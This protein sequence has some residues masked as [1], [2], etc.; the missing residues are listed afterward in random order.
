MLRVHTLLALAALAAGAAAQD[1]PAGRFVDISAEAGIDTVGVCGPRADVKKWILEVNGGGVALFDADGDG[2]LDC[3]L[4]NGSTLEALRERKPGAGNTLWLN[5]LGSTGR[6]RFVNATEGAGIGGSLWGNGVAVGDVDNDGDLDVFVA[7]FGPDALY[8][9]DGK[10]KFRSVGAEAGLTDPR[11]SSAAVFFDFDRDGVLDLF[12]GNY[13]QFDLTSPPS[14][15][16]DSQWRGIPVMRGPRGLPKDTCSLYRGLGVSPTGVP[17]FAD[18]SSASGVSGVKPSYALGVTAFDADGDG[19]DDV[20]VANDS[21][22]N[23]LFRNLGNGTFREVADEMGV[24]FDDHGHVGSGMGVAVGA[25]DRKGR[26]AIAVTNFS[27]QANNLFVP[28]A[29]G[30]F[31]DRAYEL[32]IGGPSLQ[33]LGWGCQ[34]LDADLDGWPDFFVTNG[35]VYPEADQ[36][37]SG[38]TYAQANQFF[39][40]AQGRFHDASEAVGL[41]KNRQVFRGAAFGDLDNDGDLD[42]VITVLNGKPVVLR[43]DLG[44]GRHWIAFALEGRA[45]NRSA[46]GA[47]VTLRAGGSTQVAVCQPGSSFQCSNDPRV[48]FGLADAAVVEEVTV[49]WPSGATESRSRLA[50]DRVH[51]WIEAP[52]SL[53]AP[54]RP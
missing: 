29:S 49:Q 17:R 13:I 42:A 32:G 38:T 41:A 53:P 24:A 12:V 3:W 54:K 10:A 5:E 16:G 48:R 19:L 22:P 6:V 44:N 9:N 37:G 39:R 36:P 30:L 51:A 1:A 27:G 28:D 25:F 52:S 34:F 26:F 35:H 4:T 33:R 40:N 50:V 8:V 18:V 23:Y 15:G 43:N 46:H 7:E 14:H 11:W 20:Y 31:T 21:E 45:S 2:D 47:V